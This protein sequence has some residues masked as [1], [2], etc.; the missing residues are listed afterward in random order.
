MNMVKAKI[1]I[2]KIDD[3]NLKNIS[4]QIDKTQ[5]LNDILNKLDEEE[6]FDDEIWR[7]FPF[8]KAN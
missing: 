1:K 3:M 2:L 8:R 4:E 5:Q 7:N 6:N